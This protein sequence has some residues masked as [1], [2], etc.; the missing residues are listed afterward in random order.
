MTKVV[1]TNEDTYEFADNRS[2][3]LPSVCKHKHFI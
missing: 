3:T 2:W 1:T